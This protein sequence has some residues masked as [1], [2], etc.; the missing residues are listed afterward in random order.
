VNTDSNEQ[1]VGASIPVLAIIAAVVALVVIAGAIYLYRSAST[2]VAY[3]QVVIATGPESGT[4]H[5]LGNALKQVLESTGAF[6]SVVIQSTDGSVENMRLLSGE[7]DQHA[8]L[9]FVQ[10][11]AE[12]NNKVRLVSALYDEVLHILVSTSAAEPIQTI[13]DLEGKRVTLGAAG[14]GTREL[15]QRVLT[16]FGIEVAQDL[17]MSPQQTGEALINGTVDAAFMLAAIPSQSI[18]E[19]AGRGAVRFLSLGLPDEI[20]S[21]AHAL[22]RVFPG[23]AHNII[24]RATYVRLPREAV[25]TVSVTAMLVVRED[26]EEATVRSITETLLENRVG[27]FGLAGNALIAARGIREDYDPA[28]A[29]FP[30][31]PGADSYYHRKEPPFFVEY[32]EALSLGLTL[33]LAMYSVFIAL[34]EWLRRRMKNRVDAYLLQVEQ[35][36]SGVHQMDHDALIKQQYAM[37]ELR[38]TVFSDLVDE[39]LLA[40]AAFMILQN[41]LRDELA[42]IEARIIETTENP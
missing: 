7:S 35:L 10:G 9:A 40:D 37:E 26:V 17:A 15:S 27:T 21:E 41:H 16:H 20:G 25:H 23:V 8:D 39:R 12:A 32:A 5:A 33:M 22:E 24:P 34:R 38:R 18:S 1:D 4:Y 13:Y 2:E 42:A 31:H 6:D 30:Y 3:Q 36:A 14:S 19:L 29:V 28:N 11:D